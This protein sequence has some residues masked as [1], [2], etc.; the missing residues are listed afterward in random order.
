MAELLT[1]EENEIVTQK[2]DT[3]VINEQPKDEERIL[4]GTCNGFLG[5]NSLKVFKFLIILLKINI[6]FFP[7]REACRFLTRGILALNIEIIM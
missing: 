5:E 3:E 4:V 7:F 2:S 6:A 1:L